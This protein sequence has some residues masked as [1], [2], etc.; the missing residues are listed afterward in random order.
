MATGIVPDLFK[1]A[2]IHPVHKGNGKDPRDPGSYRP[3]AILPSLSKI[4]EVAIHDSLL[5]WFEEISFLP[6]HQY[7]F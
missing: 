6:E 7:G 5:S 2:I 4:L 3:V 1:N